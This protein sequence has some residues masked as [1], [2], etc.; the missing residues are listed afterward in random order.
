MTNKSKELAVL[1]GIEPEYLIKYTLDGEYYD[2]QGNQEKVNVWVKD[3]TE[4]VAKFRKLEIIE[5]EEDY[6]DFEKPENFILFLELCYSFFG[7]MDEFN[8]QETFVKDFINL[9]L[10]QVSKI[11]TTNSEKLEQLKQQAQSVN[12]EY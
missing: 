10:N 6:P 5:Q 11:G 8:K 3:L 7:G 2:F 12:F 1:L 9:F 4:R